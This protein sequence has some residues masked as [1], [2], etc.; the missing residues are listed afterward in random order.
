MTPHPHPLRSHPVMSGS[1]VAR[2]ILEH[3]NRFGL[4]PNSHSCN[5]RDKPCLP[6]CEYRRTTRKRPA[7][8]NARTWEDLVTTRVSNSPPQLAPSRPLS[9]I[10]VEDILELGDGI[11]TSTALSP[12][13]LKR[14]SRN[15]S[16]LLEQ[17]D[18]LKWLEDQETVKQFREENICN[19]GKK[20]DDG[21]RPRPTPIF[22]MVQDNHYVANCRPPIPRRSSSLKSSSKSSSETNNH[23]ARRDS[24]VTVVQQE[25]DPIFRPRTLLESVEPCSPISV[26]PPNQPPNSPHSNEPCSP[27]YP[28]LSTENIEK[29][30]QKLTGIRGDLGRI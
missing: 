21:R 12:M 14:N 20:F 13:R 4:A 18:T 1:G 24:I 16:L 27:M 3:M 15:L 22:G 11:Q 30:Q 25:T 7:S 19:D 6:G 28:E 29:L 2:S 10:R 26:E 17:D 9:T 5:G 23:K 8:M